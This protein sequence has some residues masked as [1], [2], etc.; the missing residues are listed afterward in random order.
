MCANQKTTP[1]VALDIGNVCLKLEFQLCSQVAGIDHFWQFFQQHQDIFANEVAIEQ[2]L[3]PLD[4]FLTKCSSS[5][6]LPVTQFENAWYA[7]LGQEMPGIADFVQA[8][9]K[10]KLQPVF[11][12]NISW[13]HW[14]ICSERLHFIPQMTGA[15]LSCDALSVKPQ[16]KIYET[17]EKRYCQG[18]IPCLYL[19]DRADNIAAGL[20]R[21]WNSHLFTQIEDAWQALDSITF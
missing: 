7:I 3:M 4:L 19:D 20:E 12:S 2:G 18:G 15:V 10:K 5:L 16:A 21:G 14:H 6:G 9:V 17:L 11:F 13:P 1:I 8:L